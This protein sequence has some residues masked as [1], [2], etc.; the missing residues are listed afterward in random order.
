VLAERAGTF[1]AAGLLATA[2]EVGYLRGRWD[3]ALV[4]LTGID[5]EFLGNRSNLNPPAIGALIALHREERDKADGFLRAAGATGPQTEAYAQMP[6]NW[7]LT[8]A[9]ALQAEAGG[10]LRHALALMT[11]WL[12]PTPMPGQQTRQELMPHVVRLALAVGDAA[13]AA[14]AVTA[15]QAD[16][17]AGAPAGRVTARCCQ[18]QLD[19]DAD[20]LLAAA[21]Q[22]GREAGPGAGEIAGTARP[23]ADH[24]GGRRDQIHSRRPAR[25]TSAGR[26]RRSRLPTGFPGTRPDMP[27]PPGSVHP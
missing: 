20:G 15:C 3:D 18:A 22:G 7:R 19:N 4:H 13:T 26:P 21:D 2:A 24:R 11:T 23:D 10:D 12:D 9:W 5:S 25:S 1:R 17:D 27:G 16:A 6:A 8:A 14:A